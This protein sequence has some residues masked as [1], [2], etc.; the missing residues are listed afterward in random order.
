MPRGQSIR[1]YSARSPESTRK[2]ARVAVAGTI[3][4]VGGY[5]LAP[6][7]FPAESRNNLIPQ[8]PRVKDVLSGREDDIPVTS[9]VKALDLEGANKKL[10]EKVHTFSFPSKDGGKGR[11]DVVRVPSNNPVEDNW[12][13]G[14]GRGLGSLDADAV[15]AGVYDGHA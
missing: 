7:F 2:S 11:I 13:V 1:W 15:F 14:I 8:L 10:R 6:Y 9:P 5:A 3:L 4:V 12:S